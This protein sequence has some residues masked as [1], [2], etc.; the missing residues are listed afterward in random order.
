MAEHDL[1]QSRRR[2]STQG[3]ERS[4]APASAGVYGRATALAQP[5]RK[6]AAPP[7]TALMLRLMRHGLPAVI[8][9]AGVI[10]MC[11]G[12]YSAMIGGA[13]LIGAGGA[14]WLV[15]WFYRI[16]VES[17]AVRVREDQARRYYAHFGRWPDGR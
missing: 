5:S 16:G 7:P 3:R 11:F 13:S 8:V 14:T 1:R 6:P 9:A 12:T 4:R 15:S 17:D 10:A 2:H